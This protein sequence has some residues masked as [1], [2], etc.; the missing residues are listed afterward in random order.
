MTPAQTSTLHGISSS[1]FAQV[2]AATVV[3]TNHSIHV[4]SDDPAAVV[5]L[6]PVPSHNLDFPSDTVCPATVV[7]LSLSVCRLTSSTFPPTLSVVLLS[8]L[9]PVLLDWWVP[10]SPVLPVPRA[11]LC[12]SAC[13]CH[14]APPSLPQSRTLV[15][16]A[17]W[18]HLCACACYSAPPLLCYL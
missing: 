7:P 14:N 1:S 2:V 15:S 17:S 6:S 11:P 9:S 4:S 3:L 13:A 12:P 16:H 5:P 8:C 10:L 18:L